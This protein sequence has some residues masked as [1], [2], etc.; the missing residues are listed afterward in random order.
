[1]GNQPARVLPAELLVIVA[2]AF[3]ILIAGLP[4]VLTLFIVKVLLAV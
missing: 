1:M 4:V 3:T 2:L